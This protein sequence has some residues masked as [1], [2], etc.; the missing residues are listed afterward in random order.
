[1]NAF[2]AGKNV[3]KNAFV[4]SQVL[5]VLTTLFCYEKNKY[6]GFKCVNNIIPID[7]RYQFQ[8]YY[9]IESIF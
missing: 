7:E 1:M 5:I 9:R 6:G 4:A 8:F 3:R 2:I